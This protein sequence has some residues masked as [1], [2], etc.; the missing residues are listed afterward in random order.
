MT[1]DIVLWKSEDGLTEDERVIVKRNL[2]FFSTADSLVAN[3]LVLALYRLNTNIILKIRY[4]N[5]C[6]HRVSL[7]SKLVL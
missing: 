1:N 4:Q 6:F 5:F 2:G 3:N 7:S